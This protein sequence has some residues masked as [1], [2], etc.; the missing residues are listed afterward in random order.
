[1]SLEDQ[2]LGFC[3]QQCRL[4]LKPVIGLN[5]PVGAGKSTLARQLRQR[6]E[7]GGLRLAVA[8]IDDGSSCS[9][10]SFHSCSGS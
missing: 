3:Q 1:M 9:R 6:F 7:Q 8:S 2:L 5:G 4:G 10:C